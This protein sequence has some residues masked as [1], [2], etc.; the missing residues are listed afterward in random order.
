[1]LLKVKKTVDGAHEPVTATSGSAGYDLAVPSS[2]KETVLQPGCSLLL[3]FGIC[4]ELV[5]PGYH[6]EL[7]M[8]SGAGKSIELTNKIGVIDND[9]RGEIKANI[10]NF[11]C[12]PVTI[13]P[14]QRLCQLLIRQTHLVD[15]EVVDELS[16]TDR[17]AGGFGHTGK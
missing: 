2:F 10:R 16:V 13:S 12:V 3:S 1:M 9:Y 11:S 4:L 17:G 5:D 8:R 6:L 7:V 15:I 14:D